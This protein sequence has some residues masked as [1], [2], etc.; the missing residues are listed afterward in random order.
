M[1]VFYLLHHYILPETDTFKGGKRNCLTFLIGVII[2]VIIYIILKN[3]QL[4]YGKYLD[5]IIASFIVI[6]FADAITMAYI[7]K[8]YYGRNIF[9]ELEDEN[10]D[11]WIYDEILH[12]YVRPTEA[13]KI[14]KRLKDEKAK[15]EIKKKYEDE[16]NELKEKLESQKRVKDISENKKRIKAAKTIQRWWRAKLYNPPNGI[17]YK[18]AKEHFEYNQMNNSK[19]DSRVNNINNI[20]EINEINEINISKLINEN[21]E[22]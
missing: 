2:Y 18:K 1:A 7:Y 8:V 10:H 13:H 9:Y 12:K 6:L 14:D 3:L 15:M 4:I 5:A 11:D 22:V 21:N 20:N 19:N 17:F 16:I